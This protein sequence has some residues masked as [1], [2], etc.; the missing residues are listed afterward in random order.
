MTFFRLLSHLL[1][2]AKEKLIYSRVT[3]FW[4]SGMVPLHP[5]CNIVMQI[6]GPIDGGVGLSKPRDSQENFL[7]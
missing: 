6:S 2:C 4:T 1:C 7:V 5:L 3:L